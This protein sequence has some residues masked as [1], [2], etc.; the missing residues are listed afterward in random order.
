MINTWFHQLTQYTSFRS[1]PFPFLSLS[2]FSLMA[3]QVQSATRDVTGS[4]DLRRRRCS[5]ILQRP[6]N[7]IVS[8]YLRPLMFISCDRPLVIDQS[9]TID[10]WREIGQLATSSRMFLSRSLNF[11]RNLSKKSACDSFF[12]FELGESRWKSNRD[13]FGW[14]ARSNNYIIVEWMEGRESQLDIQFSIGLAQSRREKG[15]RAEQWSWRRG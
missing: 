13:L 10:H 4:S 9:T 14:S 8:L 15:G 2:S 7:S 1:V 3:G 5:S 12:T 11:S 6:N